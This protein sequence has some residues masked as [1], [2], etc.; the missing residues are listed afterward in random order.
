LKIRL[1]EKLLF[2]SRKILL[3]PFLWLIVQNQH[4]QS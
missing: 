1:L 4:C 2:S 3:H